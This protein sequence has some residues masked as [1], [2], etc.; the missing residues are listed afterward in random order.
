[1]LLNDG[2]KITPEI[3]EKLMENKILSVW[4]K[5]E[6][7]EV[8]SFSIQ[9]INDDIRV[10]IEQ[11]LENRIHFNNDSEMSAVSE[12]AYNIIKSIIED[13]NVEECMFEIKRKSTDIYSH[14][15]D[16][17]VLSVII[18]IKLKLDNETLK[19][20][21]LGALLHDIGLCDFDMEYNE[22]EID[23]TN[24]ADKMKYRR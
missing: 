14:M 18:G 16:V 24:A 7:V 20:I 23:E 21:A 4:V 15:I 6:T 17:S 9:D 3:V 22:V 5:V 8:G 19:T 11:V 13:E 2:V 1:M 10:S 12:E